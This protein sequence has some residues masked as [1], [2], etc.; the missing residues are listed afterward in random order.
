MPSSTVHAYP[1]PGEVLEDKYAVE[2]LVGEGAMGAVFQATHLLRQAPVALKFM[3]PTIIDAP[4]VVERFLNEGVAASRIN[5]EHVVAVLDVSKLPNG[6]PYLVMEYLEGEN[7]E[8]LLV[9]EG[10]PGLEDASRA[11]HF[12]LQVLRALQ[13]A[14]RS[15]IVHRDLKPANCFV[16]RKDDDAD[17]IKILDFGISKVQPA[18]PKSGTQPG[19]AP[20][21]LNLTGIGAALGTPLY[22][23]PEQARNP[24]NVDARSDL[25]SVAVMLY[26]LLCGRTP[27]EPES[28]SLSELFMLLATAAPV[29]LDEHRHDLPPG[30]ADVVQRGLAKSPDDRFQSSAEMADALLPY[31]DRRSELTLRQLL[32]RPSLGPRTFRTYWPR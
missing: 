21:P 6:L 1:R 30:L 13:A 20:S 25:Y 8:Q 4:G 14:H 5:N 12:V 9:R 17:F 23:S 10:K 24:T 27:F 2:R 16:V 22:V 29:S 3:S 11:V 19:V 26:E 7:L 31:A 28:G 32:H 15:G 18:P